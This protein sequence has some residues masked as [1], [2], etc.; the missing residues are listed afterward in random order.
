MQIRAGISHILNHVSGIKS[1]E[2]A[3][4]LLRV[5]SLNPLPGII[6][7]EVFKTLM[8]ECLDHPSV[9]IA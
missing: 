3:R 5:S 1:V 6:V 7:K 2:N 9:L 8:S 4:Q